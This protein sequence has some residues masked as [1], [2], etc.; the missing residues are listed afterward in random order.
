LIA[1]PAGKLL[2][3]AVSLGAAL[4]AA[5]AL[6]R[7][8]D[9][10]FRPLRNDLDTEAILESSEFRTRVR[11]NALG[12][13]EPR[14]PGPKPPGVRRIVALGDS[15]TQ[16]YGVEEHEAYP[17]LLEGLLDGVEVINLGVGAS[18]PLDYAA[19]FAE[20]G[21]AYEPDIVLV[22]LMA[23]DVSDVFYLRK[24]GVRIL[25]ALLHG[26]Q[27]RL[28]D[29][30][31]F[32]KRLPSRL[33][34]NLYGFASRAVRRPPGPSASARRPEPGHVPPPPLFPRE[35]WKDVLHA[36]TARYGNTDEVERRLA[37]LPAER[38]DRIQTVLT[39]GRK[40]T[41]ENRAM[42]ELAALLE[43]RYYVDRLELAPKYDAA[44]KE[45][46][47]LLLR[48]AAM[49][50]RVGAETIV[51][52]IPS[53]QEVVPARLELLASRGFEVDD[54]LRTRAILGDRV[55]RFGA[56]AGIPVVDLRE[57]LRAHAAEP[58]YFRHDGHWTARGHRV[59]A[60]AIAAALA[61]RQ[62]F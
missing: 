36:L 34:P 23:N 10:G 52:Y 26:E 56:E 46:T 53:A 1:G 41:E 24:H 5:D 29:A 54:G 38:L 2:L 16:G 58:I 20:V 27:D 43:P 17:R 4:T 55:Q 7:A 47:R 18:C 13:R 42:S 31:P 44:W 49:A 61:R 60:E 14:L 40:S 48:I 19:N 50:R 59:A 9:L 8:T 39:A 33:W 45:T 21:R 15:F 37:T 3:L 57:P 25:S 6:V 30:R 35:R 22:G 51:V 11:T 32:W 62:G 12:F 28:R